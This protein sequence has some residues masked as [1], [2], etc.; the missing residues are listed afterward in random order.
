MTH[1]RTP[2]LSRDTV[3]EGNF[4][5]VPASVDT[6]SSGRIGLSSCPMSPRTCPFGGAC[7]SC[8]M[9]Q[10]KLRIGDPDDK[11]ERE[12]DQVA[13]QVMRMP[14]PDAA[15]APDVQR[16]CTDCEEAPQPEEEI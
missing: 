4:S 7:H 11:Y 1:S 8:P 6:V 3:F 2:R 9:V 5:Q 12:A 16:E 10:A 13:D 14:L 15:R